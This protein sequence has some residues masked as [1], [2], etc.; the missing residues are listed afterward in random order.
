MEIGNKQPCWLFKYFNFAATACT[1]EKHKYYTFRSDW[2]SF[3]AAIAEICKLNSATL[4]LSKPPNSLV[5]QI[6]D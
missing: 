6:L 2:E 3:L 5:Y 4:N 1:L